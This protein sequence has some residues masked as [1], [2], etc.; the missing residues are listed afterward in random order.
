MTRE[1]AT[2]EVSRRDAPLLVSLPH[3]GTL[4]PD[5]YLDGFLSLERALDDTDWFVDRL[6][7]FVDKLGATVVRTPVSRS[8]IDVNRDPAGVTLYPGQATTELCP[9][10]TFDGRPLYAGDPPDAGEIAAR[11]SAFFEPY[12]AAIAEEI[13]RLSAVHAR[14]V[15]YDCHSIRSVIPRLF[16]GELPNINIGTND[17]ASADA[18][19]TQTLVDLSR[20][21]GF[22]H[23]LNGR[24]KGGYITRHYGD[25]A[26]DVHAVQIEL[27]IRGYMDEPPTDTIP[28]PPRRARMQP[29]ADLLHR[30]LSACLDFATAG[31]AAGSSATEP[32]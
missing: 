22:T 4:I 24:F 10:S 11:R 7:D 20:G 19:L 25:P 15:V 28:P 2:I 32:S 3:T 12:H 14:L 31:P 29:M 26:R 6:Y 18:G 27:A 21:S 30:F 17:G 9:T 1:A 23:V 8:V 16:D 5:G 13:D